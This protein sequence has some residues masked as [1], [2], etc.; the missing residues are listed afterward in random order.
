LRVRRLL[1][2]TA[3]SVFGK[4]KKASQFTNVFVRKGRQERLQ[5]KTCS[6]EIKG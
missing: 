6:S 4:V 1:L 3:E 5:T 2:L